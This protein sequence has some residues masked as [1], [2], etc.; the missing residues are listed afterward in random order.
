M[1]SF[2]STNCDKGDTTGSCGKAEWHDLVKLPSHD[3]TVSPQRSNQSLYFVSPRHGCVHYQ[4]V[5]IHWIS[6]CLKIPSEA[7]CWPRAWINSTST[8]SRP[9]TPTTPFHRQ[10]ATI[11]HMPNCPLFIAQCPL[12]T[13]A[14]QSWHWAKRNWG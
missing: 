2:G 13:I 14:H 9:Q 1:R 5:Y 3:P 4:V 7:Q 12:P 8:T 6:S 11:C 10:L